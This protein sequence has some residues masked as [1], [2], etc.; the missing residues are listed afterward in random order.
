MQISVHDE[1]NDAKLISLPADGYAKEQLMTII[2]R[3]HDEETSRWNRGQVSGGIYYGQEDFTNLLVD[4]Y[5]LFALSN[6]LHPDVFPYVRKMECEIVQMT[7][8][9]FHGTDIGACGT[10]TG[11][12]TESIL[13]AMKSYRDRAR[14][15]RGIEKPEIIAATTAHA[16]FDKA[17]HYFGMT[18]V[19]VPI[20]LETF[21]IDLSAVERAITSNTVV[22]VGSAPAFPHGLV[23]DIPALG[24]IAQ[25]HNVG[26]HVDSCLGG[27]LLPFVEKLGYDVPTFDFRVQGVTSITADTHKYGYAPKGSS[28]V[29]YRSQEVRHS[30]HVSYR[31]YTILCFLY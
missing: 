15:E 22:I 16:A 1:F 20:N 7:V 30:C 2:K 24:A 3:W 12:G 28:V 8:N 23:D 14:A 9:L 17:A 19:H 31:V 26:L 11:G 10:M 25:K 21:Q 29:M 18:L 4:V 27:F 13:M 5:G 6:P